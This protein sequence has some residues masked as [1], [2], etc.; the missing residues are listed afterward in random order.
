[1]AVKGIEARPV[2]GWGQ[3]GFNYVF[4][5]YYDPRMYAQEAWF[6]RAH[7]TFLD[8]AIAGG[9]PAF[10]LF[11]ALF[12]SAFVALYRRTVSR[13][14]RVILAAALV[15]YLVQSLTVF[16]NLFSYIPLAAVFAMAH[17]ASAKGVK[18]LEDAPVVPHGD[19]ASIAAP[20]IG[21]V[22]I[23]VLWF[24]NVPGMQGGH[25]LIE[26]LGS[27][28]PAA[29]LAAFKTAVG[30]G[31]FATQEVAEQ[32][33]SFATGV[34]ASQNVDTATKQEVFS[35]AV[36]V[37]KDQIAGTPL[38][39]RLWLELA[40]A[41]R[42]AGDFTDARTA[43]DRAHELS[44]KKQGILLEQGTEAVGAGDYAAAQAAFDEAYQ[45]EPA[46][47]LAA[48]YAVAG[49]VFTGDIDGAHALAEQRFGTTTVDV[50]ILTLAY[51]QQKDWPDL[52]AL[53][54]LRVS[55][56]DSAQSRFGLAAAYAAAGN[57]AAAR[58]VVEDAIDAFP[59]SEAQ[60]VSLL[61]QLGG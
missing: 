30:S 56:Q 28:D 52:I 32:L 40:I 12:V 57:F 10:L 31:T 45:L 5:T 23:G 14:E 2:A 6:D 3:E 17:A 48:S 27:Q 47:D 26:G 13:P 22:L 46:Y 36:G 38:D 53:W 29:G 21:V 59:A 58:Q 11:A 50:P 4:N 20:V 41:Y 35:Y 18:R 16:D 44:P 15:A 61:K 34:V 42:G 43:S 24:V 55:T 49:H 8:W 37:L 39:A 19:A 7:N 54:Q 51:Y 1:M 25:D 33:T 9:I 60:G